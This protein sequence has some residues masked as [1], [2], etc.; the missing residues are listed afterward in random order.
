MDTGLLEYNQWDYE[1]VL[2]DRTNLTFRKIYTLNGQELAALKE[3]LDDMLKKEYIR[4]LISEAGYPVI[5][6]KKKNRKL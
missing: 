6:I 3:W 2:K 1:I 5:F 4:P